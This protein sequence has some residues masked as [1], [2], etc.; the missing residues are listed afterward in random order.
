M[1]RGAGSLGIPIMDGHGFTGL[2]EG[3]IKQQGE[4]AL[5]DAALLGHYCD[6]HYD[7]VYILS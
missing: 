2:P 5:A 7:S 4:G 1:H 3:F 6:V